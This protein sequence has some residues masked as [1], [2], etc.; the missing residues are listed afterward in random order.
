LS[1]GDVVL[2]DSL[3]VHKVDGVWDAVL[4]HGA[5]VWFLPRYSPDLNPLMKVY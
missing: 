4:E 2:L 5:F 3:S 1:V